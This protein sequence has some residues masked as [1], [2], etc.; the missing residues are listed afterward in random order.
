AALTDPQALRTTGDAVAA[1]AEAL[2][3]LGDAAGEAKAHFVQAVALARLGKVGAC[4]AALDRALAAAR[5]ASDRRRVNEVLAGAPLAAL[6]GPSPVT[7]ASGRCLDVVRVLRITEGAPA[8]EAVALCCQAVLEALRGRTDAARR[9]IASSRRMVE[10]LGITHRLL[11]AEV[12]AGRIELLEGDAA[13]AERCLR[14]AY[15]GLRRHG[16]GIDAA[17]AAALL[18]RAL[19]AQGRAAE[20]EE[21]SRES[22]ALAG[23]DLQAAI[24][25]RGVRAEALARRGEH[26]VAVEFA[27]AAVDIAAATDALLDHAD[28]RLALAAALRAA[29]RGGEADAEEARAIELWDAKGATLL[30]DRAR[31]DVG[32]VERADRAP[33]EARPVLR[34]MR[35]NTAT[36]NAAR[37]DAAIAARDATVLPTLWADD[38]EFVEHP[39]RVVYDREGVLFSFRSLLRAR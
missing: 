19:L 35:P 21:L 17:Q 39:T 16:L 14:A 5:R 34:R 30:A 13:A 27:R 12:F 8:V 10:E 33:A 37:F 22:E 6:W 20:A 38:A 15:D 24:A 23:D 32:R 36:A 4:E 29:G 3:S 1:A 9:M 31:G 25:W 26:A 28:A 2:A 7:R 18:G 11:E